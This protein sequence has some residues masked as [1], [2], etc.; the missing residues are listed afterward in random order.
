MQQTVT[1]DETTA[2][3]MPLGVGDSHSLDIPSGAVMREVYGVR[4]T[5][6]K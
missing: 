5:N 2:L 4:T 1:A 3:E 6:P